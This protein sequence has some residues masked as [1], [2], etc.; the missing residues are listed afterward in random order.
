YQL[1][2][3]Q[4]DVMTPD[5]PSPS[6]STNHANDPVL[7]V[8]EL[9]LHVEV[10]N[11]GR[12]RWSQILPARYADFQ[13]SSESAFRRQA[14][15]RVPSVSPESNSGSPPPSVAGRSP[16]PSPVGS[17][18][19]EDAAVNDDI[20]ETELNDNGLFQV[21]YHSMPLRDP[22]SLLTVDD[23]A[24][25]PNFSQNE[26]GS[27][28]PS[29][30]FGPTTLPSEDSCDGTTPWEPFRNVTTY[31][32]MD[33]SYAHNS[34]NATSLNGLVHNVILQ[35]DFSTEH[36][37][38]FSA[39]AELDRMDRYLS[40]AMPIS[41]QSESAL[42][43]TAS[44]N[45]VTSNVRIPMPCPN[46]KFTSEELAPTLEV[47][48]V[49][50]RC[51]TEVIKTA[52]EDDT[53]LDFN[54][55]PYKQFWKPSEDEPVQRVISE[56]YSSNRALELEQEV[57][58][59][60]PKP[61][62][63]N[64][65]TVIAWLMLWSDSTHL[66]N[67]GTASLWPIYMYF[68]NLSKYT[69]C[70]PSSYAAHH[71]AYIPKIADFAK[72]VY[73]AQFGREPGDDVIYSADYPERCLCP[74]C[75][76]LKEDIAKLGTKRDMKNRIKKL[77]RDG[78]QLQARVDKAWKLIFEK[79]FGVESM[80]VKNLLD[81]ESLTPVKNAFSLTLQEHNFNI[82]KLIPVDELYEFEL[83]KWRD[84]FVHLLR[85]LQDLK[86]DS[87]TILDER[88]LCLALKF[89]D[90]LFTLNCFKGYAKFRV[91]WDS[92][93]ASFDEVIAELGSALRLFDKKSWNFQTEELPR[94]KEACARRNSAAKGTHTTHP[95]KCCFNNSTAKT[96]FLGNYPGS[97]R[98]FGTLDGTSTKTAESEHKRVK[99]FYARTNKNQYASQVARHEN[100]SRFLRKV[101][102]RV[103]KNP[104]PIQKRIALGPEDTEG[105][106]PTDPSLRYHMGNGKRYFEDIPSFIQNHKGDLA[107]LDFFK[108][109][110][111]HVLSQLL[112]D[113]G[114][115]EYTSA[116]H[117]AVLFENNRLYRHKVDSINPRTHPHI[118]VL[119]PEGSDHPFTYGRVIGIFHAN[120]VDFLWVR[121]F[122][123]DTS[124]AA[125]WKAKRLHR[126]QFYDGW[127]PLAFGF[128]DPA[129]V[130]QGIHLIPAFQWGPAD[131]IARQYETLN[132]NGIPEVET[133]DWA[134][135]YVN[136]FVDRDIFNLFR[137]GGIGHQHIRHH[138][139]AFAEDAG[140]NDQTLPHYNAN[141]ETD[142]ESSEE[143]EDESDSEDGSELGSLGSEDEEEVEDD[144]E[145]D[146]DVEP[147]GVGPEDEE[148]LDDDDLGF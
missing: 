87:L 123:Y 80:A 26:H 88:A 129:S 41:E 93:L 103:P 50:H 6:D 144:S 62:N 9:P 7:Q 64:V 124:F 146:S 19:D 74:W 22:D 3:N 52:F 43:F 140:L 102:R 39:Q 5:L 139:K 27:G 42:P 91:H 17:T 121:W 57:Y 67:F 13:R 81:L 79:G 33:W 92:S 58:E 37:E 23:T 55:R 105:L 98:Y 78:L 106:P 61:A 53:F 118:M 94:E 86:D 130:V 46:K 125:S 101:C 4:I 95:K 108:K 127:N 122:Q 138:L 60:L 31:C 148:A 113:D 75:L 49:H 14:R 77:R 99:K 141:W 66:A 85:I 20:F 48:D 137:G 143:D 36:L 12:P 116:D 54:I 18:V 40:T 72:D 68:G 45:W 69:R 35:D 76:I 21:Y 147:Q 104:L 11:N 112:N 145:I 90:L 65:E 109:L 51:L 117:S 100:R 84:V 107:M 131:S 30:V 71:I 136:I 25:A 111:N 115:V 32:L 63:P 16:S 70:K 56:A 59:T 38:G 15:D 10:K 2:N 82:F 135:Q 134:Y 89:Q 110:K 34:I 47:K 29:Q 44:D 142:S 119:S 97:V 24:D 120:R 8:A 114:S 126:I 73:L 83:G 133:D 28:T 132:I 1:S 128:L 96:H